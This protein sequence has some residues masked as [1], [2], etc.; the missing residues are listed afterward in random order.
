MRYTGAAAHAFFLSV[1]TQHEH[2][3][4]RT[5]TYLYTVLY[6]FPV[7]IAVVVHYLVPDLMEVGGATVLLQG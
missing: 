5:L 6:H 2:P 3:D 4:A 7:V 1:R